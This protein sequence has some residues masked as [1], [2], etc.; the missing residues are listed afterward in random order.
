[1]VEFRRVVSALIGIPAMKATPGRDRDCDYATRM[2]AS[3]VVDR[4]K[5]TLDPF[6]CSMGGLVTVEVIDASENHDGRVVW[7]AR[8]QVFSQSPQHLIDHCAPSSQVGE[9]TMGTLLGPRLEVAAAIGAGVG[10]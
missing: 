5:I 3:Q 8:G 4:R 1:M 7:R 9:L 6:E 10:E 2:T